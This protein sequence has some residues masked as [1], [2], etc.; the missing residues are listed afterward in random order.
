MRMQIRLM[1]L[2]AY[3]WAA[4]LVLIASVTVTVTAA[5]ASESA[6]AVLSASPSAGGYLDSVTLT[7][8]GS[9][10]I[11][12][13]WY[14]WVPGVDYMS[15]SPTNVQVPTGWNYSITHTGPS[16]GYAIEWINQSGPAL[17]AGN[18]L[19]GFSFN[20]T[21]TPATL[22][23]APDD[24]A[25]VYQGIPESPPDTSGAFLQVSV[26]TPE[27]ASLGALVAATAGLLVRRRRRPS[28]RP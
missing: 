23:G 19:S 12:S 5:R 9:T 4:A 24:Y 10:N 6:S 2:Q 27:P 1:H 15:V 25:Y 13:F 20:T 11:G 26:V 22:N 28:A 17:T 21:L 7:D 16:D 18:S 14:S 3:A 8:T